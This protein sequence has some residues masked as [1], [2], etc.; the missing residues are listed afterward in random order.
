MYSVV[1]AVCKCLYRKQKA[2]T[3]KYKHDTYSDIYS[4]ISIDWLSP[5]AETATIFKP[6]IIHSQYGRQHNMVLQLNNI[7]IEEYGAY[8]YVQA[9]VLFDT[10]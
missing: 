9:C 2:E 7:S 1:L 8:Q 10:N 4:D 3:L 6:F 5:L